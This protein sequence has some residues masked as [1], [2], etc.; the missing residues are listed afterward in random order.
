[1]TGKW[2]LKE[3]PKVL[4]AVRQGERAQAYLILGESYLVRDLTRKLLEALVPA[5]DSLEAHYLALQGEEAP[6]DRF[7]GALATYSLFAGNRV[8]H[9][10]GAQYLAG[11][12]SRAS[13]KEKIGEAFRKKNLAQGARA[14]LTFL[15]QEKIPWSD[16]EK[17]PAGTLDL[18]S[19]EEGFEDWMGQVA[20]YLDTHSLEVPE[21]AGRVE[22]LVGILSAGL[23]KGTVLVLTGPRKAEELPKELTDILNQKGVIIEAG[24]PEPRRGGG[25]KK[26]TEEF[27]QVVSALLAKVGKSLNPQAQVLLRERMGQDLEGV[28]RELEKLINYV[29][30]RETILVEDL[31]AAGTRPEEEALYELTTALEERDISRALLVLR[32]LIRQ[33]IHPL[34]IHRAMLSEWRRLSF[35]KGLFSE[36]EDFQISSSYPEFQKGAYE[37]LLTFAGDPLKTVFGKKPKAYPL[38]RLCR[39]VVRFSPKELRGGFLK[40]REMEKA[41]KGAAQNPQLILESFLLTLEPYP[42]RKG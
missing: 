37:K 32:A 18:E 33:G 39:N 19:A 25:L 26:E 24:A 13:L 34:A 7:F 31:V 30:D 38:F 16:L 22:R 1:M 11:A 3:F 40:F 17:D 9:L 20:Q 6:W 8:I 15:K 27:R 23:P 12:V 41:L 42:G 4:E 14:V 28:A 21:E 29:G 2:G 5:E 10:A 36:R 35:I